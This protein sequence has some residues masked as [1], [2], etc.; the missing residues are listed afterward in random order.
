MKKNIFYI[1]IIFIFVFSFSNVAVADINPNFGYKDS[2]LNILACGYAT[3]ASCETFL[4]TQYPNKNL[5]CSMGIVCANTIPDNPNTDDPQN[6]GVDDSLNTNNDVYELLAPIGEFKVAP[7]NIGDYFNLIFKIAI[8]LCGA[9]AVIMIVIGGIQYMGDE[10]IFG[11]TEAKSKIIKSI[12]GLLIALGSWALLNTINPDLL[13]IGGVH[14]D[15]VSAEIEEENITEV[16]IGTNVNG[17][18]V[19]IKTGSAANC[20]GGVVDIPNDIPKTKNG[21]ICK[22]L[23]DKLYILKSK[24][25]GWKITSSIRGGGTQSSCHLS[26]NSKSGN[27]VDI[28]I[29]PG[30]RNGYKKD[31]GSTNPAWG[32]FCVAVAQIGGLNYA[33]EASSIGKCQDIKKYKTYQFTS[34]PHLHINL[35]TI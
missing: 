9:L 32:E 31:T 23:L 26:G 24:T 33:N 7:K 35:I 13:G 28:Q 21:K 22:D 17:T 18:I 25:T 12:L 29:D 14:I 8:G 20:I 19:R 11:K 5:V 1:L 2:E 15:Q 16:G 6:I 30:A 10:S 3:K 27:C 4:K 34:G